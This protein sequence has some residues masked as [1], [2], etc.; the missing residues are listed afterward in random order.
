M[1]PQSMNFSSTP[2][3]NLIVAL[4]LGTDVVAQSESP[5]PR[6]ILGAE[7]QRVQTT[8]RQDK[9]GGRRGP[10]TPNN[11]NP[12]T[13]P[14]NFNNDGPWNRDV[15]AYRVVAGGAVVKATTFER[16][17]VPTIARMTDGRIIL[18][19]QHFP[20]ND[21]EHFDKVA[22]HF[23]SDDGRT[24]TTPQVI[25]M[26][27]RPEGMR[28]PFDPTLVPLPDGRVRLYFSGNMSQTFE[29]GTPAIHSAISTDGVNYTYEPG[30]RFQLAN[31]MTIDCAAVLHQDLFH[32]FVP[33]NGVLLSPGQ[34]PGS[35]AAGDRPREGVGYHATSQDGLSFTRIDDVTIDGR[36]R[37]LGNAES[38]GEHITFY[39]TGEGLNT[40]SKA[41]GRP[42][43]GFWMATSAEGQK[44]NLV[45]NPLISGGD[46]G[47]VKTRDGGLLVVITGESRLRPGG[48]RRGGTE[49]NVLPT[50]PR[51]GPG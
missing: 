4:A 33:D 14:Q 18:A 24:W 10:R 32:L 49:N 25:Q 37:W 12:Q 23:S 34:R 17:G 46:P 29:R 6:T 3:L 47:A 1:L 27:G 31:R 5:S 22:V 8:P 15:I 38:D 28:F 51:R 35:E 9:S 43:G 26:S 45:A 30:V 41:N 2:I 40:A 44:W 11:F 19:H 20:E 16:A 42:S 36:R 21:R 48:L 7:D 13:P 39:G 50:P